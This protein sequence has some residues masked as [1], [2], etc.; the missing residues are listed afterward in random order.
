LY[1][2]INFLDRKLHPKTLKGENPPI[3]DETDW[4]KKESFMFTYN[5][6]VPRLEAPED[7]YDF[8]AISFL[9]DLGNEIYRQDANSNEIKELYEVKSDYVNIKRTFLVDRTTKSWSIW[10]HHRQSGWVKQITGE[11]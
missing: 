10:I 7:D 2:G 11:I 5:I 6:I 9:D 4:H 3:N 8:W 1:A